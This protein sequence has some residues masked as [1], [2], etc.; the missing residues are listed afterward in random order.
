MADQDTLHAVE[1]ESRD[2]EEMGAQFDSERK[3][4]WAMREQLLGRY[5]GEYV[6][7]YEGR[8][9]DHDK[10]KLTLGLRVYRQ[11]GYKPIYV[12]L[13]TRQG[14]PVKRLAST[15]RLAPRL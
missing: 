12:Q 4:F 1:L 11:H 2:A 7:V 9:V 5:E 14:L 10:D 13:V 3:T 8:V 15:N 6:A